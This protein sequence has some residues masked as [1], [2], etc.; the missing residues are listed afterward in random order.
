MR[1]AWV[2]LF[3]CFVLLSP[4]A[5]AQADG[6]RSVLRIDGDSFVDQ[7]SPWNRGTYFLGSGSEVDLIFGEPSG[8]TLPVTVPVDGLRV[9][10]LKQE[11][12]P[13]LDLRLV[14]PGS[15]TLTIEGPDKGALT[16]NVLVTV[17]APEIDKSVT[18]ALRLSTGVRELVDRGRSVQG[19]GLRSSDGRVTLVASARVKDPKISDAGNFYAVLN[20]QIVPV[21][22]Q[23]E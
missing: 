7:D 22:S 20:G 5:E 19:S 4:Q 9:A 3:A 6:V 16:I 11:R 18:Y 8:S 2:V 23:L 15:G 14:A 12:M 21:P 10:R 1:V 17:T 13:A